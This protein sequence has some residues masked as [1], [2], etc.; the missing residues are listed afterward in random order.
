MYRVSFEFRL[1]RLAS[2][3]KDGADFYEHVGEVSEKLTAH[4]A[5]SDVR[6]IS[7][8]ADSNLIFD[9]ALESASSTVV[10]NDALHIVRAAIEACGAR[11]FGMSTVARGDLVGAGARGGLSTPSWHKQRMLVDVAA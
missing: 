9:F 1:T 4:E 11:H 3:P 7:N 8:F 2:W 10:I 6:A 5:V